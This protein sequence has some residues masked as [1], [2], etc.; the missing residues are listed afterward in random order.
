MQ[1]RE[2]IARLSRLRLVSQQTISLSR[3]HSKLP[4]FVPERR[5]SRS[6][7]PSSSPRRSEPELSVRSGRDFHRSDKSNGCPEH[8]RT[9]VESDVFGKVVGPHWLRPAEKPRE[10]GRLP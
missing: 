6:H 4:N 10:L 1:R 7:Q 3:L 9:Q 8:A 2:P 5:K